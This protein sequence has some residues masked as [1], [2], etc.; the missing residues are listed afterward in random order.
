MPELRV[1]DASA[2]AVAASGALLMGNAVA[3][4]FF[5]KFWRR[6]GAPVF[7][8]FAVAF[9]L[10][11]LQRLTLVALAGTPGAMPWSYLVRLLAFVL[12]LVGIAAQNRG[13]R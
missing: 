6:T 9:V 2:L 11:A 7:A 3:A 8:W 10:L 5:A 12:I 1:A 13:R 4:L